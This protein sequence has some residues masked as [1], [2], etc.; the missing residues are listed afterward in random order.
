LDHQADALG[1]PQPRRNGQNGH[2]RDRHNGYDRHDDRR[3]AAMTASQR[4]AILAIVK[5][6]DINLDAEC[7]DYTGEEFERLSIRQASELIDHLK[8][9]EPAGRH[10]NRR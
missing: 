1:D 8:A 10:D 4:R 5:R 6:W 2:G 3:D 7:R 9:T